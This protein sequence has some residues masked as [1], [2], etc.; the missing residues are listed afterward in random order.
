[1][2]KDLISVVVPIYNG[3]RFIP[4][5]VEAIR[6]QTW[7]KLEILLVD[8]GSTDDSL[9]V[10]RELAAA[11]TRIRVLHKENGGLGSARNFGMDHA[12]GEYIGFCDVDDTMDAR[13]Y[14]ALHAMLVET[15]ADFADCGHSDLVDGKRS[16]PFAGESK[17]TRVVSR[18]DALRL[19]ATGKGITWGVWDKLFR[20]ESCGAQRFPTGKDH[21][22]DVL[23]LLDFIKRNR[24]FC[25]APLGYY[26]YNRSNG[27]SMTKQAW[28]LKKLGLSRFYRLLAETAEEYQLT[29]VMGLTAVRHYENLLSVYIRCRRRG[30]D[31]E[32]ER[33]LAEMRE[34]RARMLRSALSPPYKADFLLCLALP[35]LAPKLHFWYD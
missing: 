35:R 25:W 33:L 29:D 22:E 32:A 11:D 19:F 18:E 8:D 7:Q 31:E 16:F 17:E 5:C 2:T 30:Y 9:R 6:A 12:V 28:S 10:C 23:F 20:A 26:W 24:L 34:K 3:Q 15:G 21:G 4:A 13:M 1:M 14:E 27:A